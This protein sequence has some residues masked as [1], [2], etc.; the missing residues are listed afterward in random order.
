MPSPSCEIKDGSGAY[1]SSVD[2]VNVTPANTITIHLISSA[3]VSTWSIQCITTDELSDADTVNSGLTIDSVAKT[4]TFTAPATGAAY[5]FQSIINGGIDANGVAQSSYSTTFCIYTLTIGGRRVHAVDETFES[6]AEF[7]WIADFN[8]FVRNPASFTAPTGTGFATTTAGVM[9]VASLPFPLSIAKGGTALTAVPGSASEVLINSGGTA[10]SAAT[11]VT[12]GSGFLTVASGFLSVTSGYLAIGST[13]ASAG[14]IRLPSSAA[15]IVS[16]KNAG[17]SANLSL[18]ELNGSDD[19]WIG[20]DVGKTASKQIDELIL[21]PGAGGYLGAGTGGHTASW[22]STSFYVNKTLALFDSDASS[23]YIFSVSNLAADRAVSLP[24]LTGNDTF[25]FEAHAQALSNKT[26]LSLSTSSV[27]SSGYIRVPYAATDAIIMSK[28]AGGTD[29]E[30]VGRQSEDI[31]Q[32]GPTSVSNSSSYFRGYNCVMW[33]NASGSITLTTASL[34]L[35]KLSSTDIKTAAP[36]AGNQ[37]ESV[38]FRVKSTSIDC[39]AIGGSSHTLSAAEAECI[40]ITLTGSPIGN[41]DILCP[42]TADALYSIKNSSGSIA[43]IK[44]SGGTGF[45][46]AAAAKSWAFHNGTDYE[47]R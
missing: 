40:M 15:T 18:L 20:S 33:C 41:F 27:P 34:Q 9:D 45:T 37:N 11:G 16:A 46:I 36:L 4:A 5:R 12:A 7:G 42:N 30:I 35:M 21:W 19:L 43:T 13:V 17:G 23:A 44:K 39:T 6:S 28:T 14:T 3:G 8:D 26:Y 22:S 47:A 25:V 29:I 10:F 32:F 31:F 1:Q 24:L 2:G 38:P